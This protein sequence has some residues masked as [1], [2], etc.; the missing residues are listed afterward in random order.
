MRRHDHNPEQAPTQEAGALL[1]ATALLVSLGIVMNYSTTA[2]QALGDAIPPMALRHMLG[3][4]IAMGWWRRTDSFFRHA[5][6]ANVAIM[7]AG[8]VLVGLQLTGYF[9]S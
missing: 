7:C 8:F 3:V 6:A 1:T 5:Y 9:V 4:L 2:A